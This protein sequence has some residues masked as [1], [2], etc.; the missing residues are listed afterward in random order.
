MILQKNR[1]LSKKTFSWSASLVGTAFLLSAP[2]LARMA[3][4]PASW[5]AQNLAHSTTSAADVQ[6]KFNEIQDRTW[7]V[8]TEPSLNFKNLFSLES[9]D[10]WS[11]TS[12]K[13]LGTAL[14]APLSLPLP[15]IDAHKAMTL[16]FLG[17]VSYFAP[18][19][20]KTAGTAISA[21][22][23]MQAIGKIGIALLEDSWSKGLRDFGTL[24]IKEAISSAVTSYK[25][26]KN[27]NL[28]LN[29]A[30]TALF[31]QIFG[32]SNQ[33][34]WNAAFAGHF[35]QKSL[36]LLGMHLASS[37]P[38]SIFLNKAY[39]QLPGHYAAQTAKKWLT[40]SITAPWNRLW[41]F[42]KET[43]ATDKVADRNAWLL[44]RASI[45]RPVF[46]HLL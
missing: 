6:K 36:S 17:G 26:E 12:R 7:S 5:D 29:Q 41:S 28:F 27:V 20:A 19:H 32:T 39:G 35:S 18:T 33:T 44:V 23:K 22:S 45:S 10:T 16:A 37:D 43:T 40:H 8:P 34:P 1:L 11:D 25:I 15:D 4:E 31:T 2:L 30:S 3:P 14:S 13:I 9:T 24:A 46:L 21:L 42:C 38:Y